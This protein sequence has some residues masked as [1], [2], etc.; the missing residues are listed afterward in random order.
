[1]SGAKVDQEALCYASKSVE[2][3]KFESIRGLLGI[4]RGSCPEVGV[5]VHKFGHVK[6]VGSMKSAGYG[7]E[8]FDDAGS[9]SKCFVSESES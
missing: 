9:V 5:N 2:M 1:M 4:A 7:S 3:H 6:V 8:L